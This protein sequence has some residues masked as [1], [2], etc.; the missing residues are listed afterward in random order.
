MIKIK[1]ENSIENRILLLMGIFGSMPILEV[2]GLTAFTV[3]MLVLCGYLVIVQNDFSFNAG[4]ALP[5]IIITISGGVTTVVSVLT[6]MQ[7]M[8]KSLAINNMIWQLLF[9][10][11]FLVYCSKKRYQHIIYYIKGVYYGAIV[12]S[13][14]GVLQLT[15]WMFFKISLNKLVFFDVLRIPS[16]EYIQMKGSSIAIT[17]LCWNAGNLAPLLVIGYIFSNSIIMKAFFILIAVLCG[18]RTALL[19]LIICMV[20]EVFFRAIKGNGSYFIGRRFLLLLTAVIGAGLAIIVSGKLESIMVQFT[21][22][23]ESITVKT[24]VSQSSSRVHARYWTTIPRITLWNKPLNNLFGYGINTSGYPF[25]V[26]FDQ[27]ADHAWTVESDFVNNLWGIGY[28]GFF[29][30][31]GW[32]LY[33]VRKSASIDSRYLILFGALLIEG[34]TYNVTFNWCYV[35]LIL[36]FV[37]IFYNYNVFDV[38]SVKRRKVR[39]RW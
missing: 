1:R 8:W 10:F 12:H 28:V 6:D 24:L 26:L 13:V 14:W 23:A 15:F 25:A 20:G 33:N 27:Y 34:V 37:V 2:F 18:S 31:Y 17:G 9:L 39:I 38:I 36:L 4:K 32:Y 30:W 35:F 16:A 21:T 3:M 19:G 5:L 22:M 29:L 7:E 11:V